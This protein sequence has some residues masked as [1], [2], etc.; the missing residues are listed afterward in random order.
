MRH[1]IL[2]ALLFLAPLQTSAGPLPARDFARPA[3]YRSVALSP[4]GDYLAVGV[5]VDEQTDLAV[6]RVSD[7][8]VVGTAK[9]YKNMHVNQIW[10]TSPT[11]V[12]FSLSE[13]T[14]WWSHQ[15]TSYG[16]FMAI[17]A[18][19]GHLEYLFGM[20]GRR[21]IGRKATTFIDGFGWPLMR[22]PGD[23]RLLL[24][25][26]E[27][28]WNKWVRHTV[29]LDTVEGRRKVQ[30]T[31]D[32]PDQIGAGVY[33]DWQ[34][35]TRLATTWDEKTD[36]VSIYRRD[37]ALDQWQKLGERDEFTPVGVMPDG[38]RSYVLE[39]RVDSTTCL[40]LVK[41]TSLESTPV[42][43]D[44]VA[45]VESEH[46]YRNVDR[47]PVAVLLDVGV[48]QWRAIEPD[49]PETK[50]LLLLQRSF[51]GK[52]VRPVNWTRARDKLLL[53][54]GS[55]RD[56]GAYYLFDRQRKQASYLFD[57][58]P[59]IDATQAAE[60]RAFD[61]PSRDGA[62]LH[63]LITL[64]HG[65]KP[66]RLPMVVVPHGGPFG[67][68]DTWEW[69][70]DSQ[71][72]ASRGYAVLR[73]NFRASSGYGAAYLEAAKRRWGTMM[74]DDITDGVHWALAEGYADAGRICIYGGSYGGYAALMSA[75]REPELY[76]CV[77]GFAGAYDLT[78]QLRKSD[79]AKSKS[80]RQYL[81]EFL[82][83]DVKELREQSPINHLDTLA[84]PVFIVHGKYDKRV[85]YAQ[86]KALR[87]A[88]DARQ[89]PYEWMAKVETHGF[90]DVDNQTELYERMQQFIERYIGSS[91]HGD[92]GASAAAP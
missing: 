86:S 89:L 48:P 33:A 23:N 60:T 56:P 49:D 68:R 31:I 25:T 8:R 67:V 78:M 66:A 72:L 16:E 32:I 77:V 18:D 45:D 19:G 40:N 81:N 92:D 5:P 69:E 88:L 28:D 53:L 24:G 15:L 17:D 91:A 79:T 37:P 52:I 65:V 9:A 11:R 61:F 50:L 59:W 73:V 71:F 74:I 83:E 70:S 12:V 1:L 84:A 87:D 43:C 58:R 55:D 85:P 54:V 35:T 30:S 63:G 39:S 46:L 7:L 2:I 76:R 13:R 44:D 26:V 64:P 51:P 42:F 82:G 20:R 57:L 80:G 6:L 38:E 14:D 34:G 27:W 22:L 90:L 21:T 41:L 3:Q 4:G 36:K 75:V 29:E 62:T 10:W 47:Q